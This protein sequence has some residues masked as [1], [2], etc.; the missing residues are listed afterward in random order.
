M[1]KPDT[2]IIR[3]LLN[4]GREQDLFD[5]MEG[6]SVYNWEDLLENLPGKNGDRERNMDELYTT[7]LAVDHVR[8]IVNY[9]HEKS[10]IIDRNM[11]Y[12]TRLEAFEKWLEM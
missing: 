6:D 4:E 8:F 9:G 3:R 10:Q 11:V 2:N 7:W 5:L 1:L 12:S